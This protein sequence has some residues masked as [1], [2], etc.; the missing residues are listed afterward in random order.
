MLWHAS[1]VGSASNP[2]AWLEDV[3][4]TRVGSRSCRDS[5][6]VFSGYDR[7]GSCSLQVRTFSQSAFR[8]TAEQIQSCGASVYG[9][10]SALLLRATAGVKEIVPLFQPSEG[11]S[12]G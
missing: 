3:E 6:D 7:V 10:A 1:H 11:I 12:V 8:C 2:E 4:V 5:S 9:K